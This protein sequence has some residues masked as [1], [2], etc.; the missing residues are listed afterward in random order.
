[1]RH[2]H[3]ATAPPAPIYM[4]CSW[5]KLTAADI[6][7]AVMEYLGIR[8]NLIVPNVHWG[9]F[10]H[11]CDLLVIT[12]A[13]YAWEIEIKVSK[14]DLIADKKKEHGHMSARIKSLY[15]AMPEEM[16]PYIEHVPER[17]G[18][19]LVKRHNP[20]S[21][22][23]LYCRTIRRPAN[24]KGYKFSIQERYEVARLGA[25]RILGLKKKLRKAAS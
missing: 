1:M 12:K 25:M 16:E 14:A 6:E 11:E 19:I 21:R 4:E 24:Y 13:G 5:R 20:E 17:A 9:L 18:I 10:L 15:F 8:A 23:Y 22:S 2:S 3:V 7:I